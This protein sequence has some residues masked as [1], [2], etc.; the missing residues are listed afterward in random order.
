MCGITGF[1]DFTPASEE[2]EVLI[3]TMTATMHRRGPDDQRTWLDRHVA[4]GVRR[5]SVVDLV[6][7]VQ[8]MVAQRPGEPPV[9]LAYTGEV[10]NCDELRAELRSHGHTFTTSSD[11]EVV[12]ASYLQWGAAC[13]ERLLGM[14]AFAVWDGRTDE[15]H[16]IRDRFGIYPMYYTEVPG[17][18]VFG[19]ALMALLK[20]PA[21]EPVVDTEGL[22]AIVD[23]V[24]A[25]ENGIFAG[26]KEVRGGTIV[27]FGRNGLSVTTYWAPPARPHEDDLDTTVGTVREL[28]EDSVRRQ[29]HSDVPLGVF[30][31]GGLDSSALLAL[32]ARH[33]GGETLRTY[34]ID[35][36]GHDKNFTPDEVRSTPDYPFVAR[37]VEHLGT[38][39]TRV[40][41]SPEELMDPEVRREVLLA[42]DIPT[43]LG[44]LD[45]SYLLLARRF[46]QDCTVALGG[47]GADELFGGYHW[48]LEDRFVDA[49]ALPWLEFGRQMAG[50]NGLRN[51]GLI[52]QDLVE[53][54]GS[55]EA[56]RD[57]YAT[58]VAKIERLPGES[59]VDRKIRTVTYLNLTGYLRIILDR[60]DRIGMA[61][62]LEG[63]VPFLDHRLVEYVYNVPWAMK[64]FDGREKS[65][66]RAAVRD[67]LPPSVL[68]RKKA[69]YPPI[70]DP[71][72]DRALRAMVTELLAD[73]SAP[74][75]PFLDLGTAK[76]Y[77]ADP[78]SA[79]SREKVNRFSLEM[80]L[81]LNEWLATYDARLAI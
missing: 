50:K 2:R 54:L 27:R 36:A 1:V 12:L 77:L 81:Y 59:D 74:I 79:A 47:E 18:F 70:D 31:S 8:P 46:R 37:M 40:V 80:V 64:S 19:S 28:L 38:D 65:L 23:F 6:G 10:F 15:V 14:F 71:G 48:F 44:D 78:T 53:S 32:A 52:N 69:G 20:H 9:T 67:L 58:E 13:A 26:V 72:Y 41:V 75:Q 21:V 55:D 62:S 29:L 4:L 34:S 66:L 25:P 42:R 45:T 16:L 24:K 68:Y 61:V 17:G 39:H 60:K 30:L 76:S 5:L 7:G 63:R 3:D 33:N 43:S 22:R 49:Q 35:F 57:L 56:E 51:T 73:G 11:T